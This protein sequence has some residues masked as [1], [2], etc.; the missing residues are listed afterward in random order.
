MANVLTRPEPQSEIARGRW[1]DRDLNWMR[2]VTRDMDR[3]FG[4]LGFRPLGVERTLPDA[5]WMPEMEV[6]ERDGRLTI[7]TDLPGMKKEDVKVNV[8]D[9]V[10]TI[11]GERRIEKDVKEGGFHRTERTYGTFF[12]SLP[13]PDGVK[14]DKVEAIFKDGVLEIGMPIEEVKVANRNVE[15][16]VG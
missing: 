8:Q 9:N 1:F 4:N 14:L 10:L 7:R 3:I 15:V 6:F 16:K 5:A 12:R 11:E 2:H 13:L